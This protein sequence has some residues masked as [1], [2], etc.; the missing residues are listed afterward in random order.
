MRIHSKSKSSSLAVSVAISLLA[1]GCGSTAESAESEQSAG[2]ESASYEGPIGSSDVAAGKEKFDTFCGDCHPDGGE[3]VGP[4]LIAD[5]H[6]PARMR[7]QVR[8]GSGRMR[9]FSE[10][11]LSGDDLEAILAYLASIEAV[12]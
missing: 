4:S 11:R 3:D 5:P 10:K 12:K 7:Q 8:E 2:G 9:P 1:A 6:S